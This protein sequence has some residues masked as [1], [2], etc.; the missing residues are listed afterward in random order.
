MIIIDADLQDPPEVVLE[1]VERWKQ[2][3]DVVY[4]VRTGREGETFFKRVT[5]HLFYRLLQA[6]ISI[7]IPVDA[8]DFRL[9]DRQA[10]DAFRSMREHDRFVRGMFTWVGFRQV[11]VPYARSARTTGHTKYPLG[12]MLRLAFHGIIGFSDLPLRLSI[13]TGVLIS[14]AALLYGVYV[15]VLWFL[16]RRLVEGWTSTVVI[17]TFLGGINL[18]MTG[19][20]GLYV[21]RIHEE[22]K[23]RPLYIVNGIHGFDELPQVERAVILT[24][25]RTGE[26]AGADPALRRGFSA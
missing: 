24:K 12:K 17:L 10:L 3:Y 5:A 2:G 22:V 23:N 6:M 25:A 13:W 20:V 7:S 14:N 4:G 11:G 1:M 19:V 8:G 9:V 16:G 26:S 21:G 18:I 15:I